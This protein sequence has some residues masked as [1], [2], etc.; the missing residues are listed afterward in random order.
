MK[1]KATLVIGLAAGY[2]LGARAGQERYEEIKTQAKRLLHD[3]RVQKKAEQA[4][5]KVADATHQAADKAKETAQQ[6]TQQA[7][8]QKTNGGDSLTTPLTPAAASTTPAAPTPMPPP[9]T[10]PVAPGHTGE[11]S[12]V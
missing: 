12:D 4:Q 11:G 7:T 2:V 9:P 10:S 3:P 8:Q 5:A 1:S 6:A